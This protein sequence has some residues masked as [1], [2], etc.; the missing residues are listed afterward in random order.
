[1]KNKS[2]IIVLSI[3]VAVLVIALAIAIIYIMSLKNQNS[4]N[5]KNQQIVITSSSEK[6]TVDDSNNTINDVID[7]AKET[8][9][10]SFNALFENYVGNNITAAQVK[11]LMERVKSNSA[12]GTHEITLDNSGIVSTSEIDSSKSYNAELSYD[13]DGYVSIIKITESTDG[14]VTEPESDLQ[15]IV[16][17]AQFTKYEGNITGTDVIN[18]AQAIIAS[19]GTNPNHQIG[20]T[21]VESEEHRIGSF[22]EIDSAGTYKTVISYDEEGWV[23]S[24]E[25]SK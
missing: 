15:K 19:N 9:K 4:T 7:T 22:D 16:F 5:K 3:I 21:T 17:N 14:P 20:V 2:V 13:D 18:M 10:A 1:M 12:V 8:E 23:N 24:I 11:T 6:N 25:I